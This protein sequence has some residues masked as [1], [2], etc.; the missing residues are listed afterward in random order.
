VPP[1]EAY[2]CT[3][4]L[5]GSE[6][7]DQCGMLGRMDGFLFAIHWK[8]SRGRGEIYILVNTF[9]STANLEPRIEAWE[10]ASKTWTNSSYKLDCLYG[11]SLEIRIDNIVFG[12]HMIPQREH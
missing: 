10:R 11:F 6:G 9:R 7:I 5:L 3:S 12:V 8:P 2:V 1:V 4:M